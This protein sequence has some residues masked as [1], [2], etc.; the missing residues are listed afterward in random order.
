[1]GGKSVT[2]LPLNLSGPIVHLGGVQLWEKSILPNNATQPGLAPGSLDA[3]P[4]S[5][6]TISPVET[7][8]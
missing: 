2:G 3:T 1:M 4:G 7:D 5:Q 8:C 6:L